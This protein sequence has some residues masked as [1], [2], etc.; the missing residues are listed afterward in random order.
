MFGDRYVILIKFK[1]G[2]EGYYCRMADDK[3]FF[4]S[5]PYD[6]KIYTSAF[7]LGCEEAEIESSFRNIIR[8]TKM[9]TL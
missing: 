2:D 6:A 1:N 9:K 4:T 5:N 7:K 3:I 8:K